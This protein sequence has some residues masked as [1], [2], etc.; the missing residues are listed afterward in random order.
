MGLVGIP[1]AGIQ[2]IQCLISW[3]QF[4]RSNR[5]AAEGS[6][7]GRA[8]AEEEEEREAL[9]DPPGTCGFGWVVSVTRRWAGPAGILCLA[10]G[11]RGSLGLSATPRAG[12][13]LGLWAR[14]VAG[15]GD[16]HVQGLL[17]LSHH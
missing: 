11:Y 7:S 1:T 2:R 9:A 5:R 17:A 10:P 4:F 12:W 16:Q 13:Q 8:A 14:G 6:R 15:S 3:Q